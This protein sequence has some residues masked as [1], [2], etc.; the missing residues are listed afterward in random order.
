MLGISVNGLCM[1]SNGFHN[2]GG[3]SSILIILCYLKMPLL[4]I[5]DLNGFVVCVVC[6]NQYSSLNNFQATNLAL[7]FPRSHSFCI[8]LANTQDRFIYFLYSDNDN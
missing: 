7:I 1:V 5:P 3:G 6:K 8:Y 4:K 2:Q